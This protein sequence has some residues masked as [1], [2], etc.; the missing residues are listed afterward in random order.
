MTEVLAGAAGLCAVLAVLA[1]TGQRVPMPR[2]LPAPVRE[3]RDREIAL[4][5]TLGEPRLD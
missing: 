4:A 5:A 1:L 2:R 3:L